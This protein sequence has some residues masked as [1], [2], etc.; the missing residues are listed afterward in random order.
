MSFCKV[1]F[2]LY[3]KDQY[4]GAW[5]MQT[6]PPMYRVFI[7]DELFTERHYIWKGKQF[8]RENLQ[9][10]A[11]PGHYKIRFESSEEEKFLIRNTTAR[12][13]SVAVIDS[14][15]FRILQ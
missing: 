12:Y 14:F 11:E 5:Y 1:S 6:Q 2:D 9:I 13:G 3:L 10:E 8:L 4:N 7:N 15:N